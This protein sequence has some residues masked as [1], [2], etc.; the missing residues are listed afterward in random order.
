MSVTTIKPFG[1]WDFYYVEGGSIKWA[2]NK[3]Q[4]FDPVEVPKGFV[5]DLAS[6]PRVFWSLLKPEGRYAYAA[7][8]H[9]YLYWDQSRSREEADLILKFAMEDSKV[10][11]ITIETIYLAVK[12]FGQT[13][14]ANNAKMK[15]AGE[16]RILK[17]FP[18]DFT[19]SWEEW[20]S[21]PG[22]FA[23]E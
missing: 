13:A 1:D 8:V 22:V 14:W 18:S 2:P 3:G 16:H 7:V 19:T 11:P 17:K 4:N 15:E 9:D 6:I 12:E 10:Q 5:T 21:Q 23:D 20:K